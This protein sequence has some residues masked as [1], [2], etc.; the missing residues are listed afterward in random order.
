MARLPRS[1]FPSHGVWHVTTRGVER[2]QVYLDVGDGRAFL[3]ELWQ[4]V[5]RFELRALALCLMP[6]HY[7]LVVEAARDALSS[8]LHRVNGR[9]AQSF[10]V[11]HGRS[12]HLWGDRFALRQVRDDEHL[13]DACLYVVANPVRA[14]LCDAPSDWPWSWSRYGLRDA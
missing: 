9:Y 10:N 14:R 12:G 4:A 5:E 2:R 3:T 6:N 11:K 7:H 13:R 8:A 1:A